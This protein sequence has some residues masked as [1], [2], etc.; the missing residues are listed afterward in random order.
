MS[1]TERP[2]WQRTSPLAAV[3]YLGKIYQA[4]AKNALQ[5][6]AP[7]AAFL[8]AFQGNKM[9]ALIAGIAVFVVATL[10][11]AF[12]RYWFFR[13]RIAADSIL[14]RDGVFNKKQLDIKF[15]RV[16]GINTTQNLI[17][18][19]F[20]LVT[21]SFDT[22]GTSR[23][24]GALPA[25]GLDLAGELK[26]RIRRTPSRPD[27]AA[28][29]DVDAT[30]SQTASS[31]R[32]LVR[33]S[34][35]D[36]VR[37]GLSSSR[38]FLILILLGP[39]SEQVEQV[40]RQWVA[41]SEV[42]KALGVDSAGHIDFGTG[43]TFGLLI[44]L[45]ILFILLASSVI[46][47]FLRYHRYELIADNDV[48]RSV[49]GL[50]TRQEQAVNRSK[51]QSLHVIQNVML[52]LFKQ[53]RLRARQATS[54]RSSANSRFDIP[55]CGYDTLPDICNEIFQQEFPGLTFDPRSSSFEPISRYYLR[56]RIVLFG[57]LPSLA[58]LIALWPATG[59]S[60]LLA[61]LW[62]PVG[63]FVAWRKYRR[64]GVTFTDN[65]LALR[66]G[67]IG[68]RV[69]LWLH[70]KVQRV[71]IT[72]SPFQRRKQLATIHFYLAAGSVSI[73]FVNYAAAK[74]LRDYV[75]YAV[76]SSQLAWH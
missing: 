50:L 67:F 55:I 35:G 28:G 69:I 53:F 42:L 63:G 72:Q 66:S 21:V 74:K 49:G 4:L 25:V 58:G 31:S 43:I 44:V 39:L 18:R 12:L 75:L 22:A 33:L 8:V 64:F 17:F 19:L 10:V 65:G 30:T 23:R 46:A 9:Y 45:G 51:I 60:A 15:E 59:P 62:I 73:P 41:E 5:S 40:A 11:H 61:L 1:K 38:V 29:I 47:A 36:V 2:E 14:I 70:R 34:G 20:N 76:E 52:R 3:F 6:L 27:T 7:L 13:Y 68:Y 48:L 26:D 37:I 16:Q 54:G 57:I 56:S 24:E 71:S 32:T